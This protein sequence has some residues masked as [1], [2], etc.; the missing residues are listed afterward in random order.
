MHTKI[1]KILPT[2]PELHFQAI[3]IVHYIYHAIQNKHAIHCLEFKKFESW[4]WSD[5]SMVPLSE[6]NHISCKRAW[7][8][9]VEIYL[10]KE[11]KMEEEVQLGGRKCWKAHLGA[12]LDLNFP[13]EGNY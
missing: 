9:V 12:S 13:V 7:L 6:Y 10:S 8:L 11:I 4:V 2:C 3:Y 5:R 1:C